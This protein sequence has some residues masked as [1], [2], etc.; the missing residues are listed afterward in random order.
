MV[1]GMAAKAIGRLW[2]CKGVLW[3]AGAWTGFAAGGLRC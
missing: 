1:M 3:V 2:G